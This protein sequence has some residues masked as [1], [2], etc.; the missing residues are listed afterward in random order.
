[1]QKIVVGVTSFAIGGGVGA[2]THAMVMSKGAASV[3]VAP[4]MPVTTA[5]PALPE[6]APSI[7]T[8]AAS[9]LP[10]VPTTSSASRFPVTP[11]ANLAEERRLLDGARASLA[12]GEPASAMAPLDDHLR[13]FPRGVL[14]EERE[15]L[16]IQALARSGRMNEAVE[17]GARFQ[18]TYPTSLMAPAVEDAL[19]AIRDK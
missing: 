1:M 10:A 9:S 14:A 2:A 7:P 17:R 3:S 5:P 18:R 15:A 19:G 6:P 11:A 8:V 12:H 4:S 16:A 13:R